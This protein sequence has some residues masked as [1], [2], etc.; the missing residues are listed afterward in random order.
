M[1]W[2]VWQRGWFAE[3]HKLSASPSRV[4]EITTHGS[5]ER[6]PSPGDQFIHEEREPSSQ[7][8]LPF[9]YPSQTLCE[10]LHANIMKFKALLR[11]A[12]FHWCFSFYITFFILPRIF[13]PFFSSRFRYQHVGIQNA[14]E[15]ARKMQ[16]K[17]EK[18]QNASPTR[19]N[20]S[21]LCFYIMC[22]AKSASQSRFA[23]ILLV[24]CL[25]FA[26]VLLAFCSHFAHILLTNFTKTQTQ[27]I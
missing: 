16:E 13:P 27:R 5:D 23:C 21:I 3:L 9:R 8:L 18:I 7:L 11:Y 15:K 14:S 25:R 12:L 17:C 24:F 6:P 10:N 1:T 20:V 19:E 4:P 26:C 2:P 22:W